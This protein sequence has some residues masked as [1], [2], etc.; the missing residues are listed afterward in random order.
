MFE[1]TK[2]VT[3]SPHRLCVW[4]RYFDSGATSIMTATITNVSLNLEDHSSVLRYL[5]GYQVLH[6]ERVCMI[7]MYIIRGNTTIDRSVTHIH[8]ANVMCFA[9]GVLTSR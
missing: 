5:K 9:M 8:I 1:L 4:S 3:V 7:M 6:R 2:V